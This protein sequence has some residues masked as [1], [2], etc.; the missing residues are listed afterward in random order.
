M[1]MRTRDFEQAVK[2]SGIEV[3]RMQLEK[4]QVKKCF[5]QVS[6]S[7][8]FVEWD[9]TGRAFVFTQPED[10]ECCVSSFNMDALPYERD[11]K[12]DLVFD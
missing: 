3:L 4:G 7:C 2:D 10:E 9:E 8:T 6:D 1:L 11:P 12:F 5:G